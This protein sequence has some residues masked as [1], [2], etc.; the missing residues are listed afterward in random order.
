M[1][2]YFLK[3]LHD[4]FPENGKSLMLMFCLKRKLWKIKLC[5]SFLVTFG[6]YWPGIESQNRKSK[7]SSHITTELIFGY[8][9][10]I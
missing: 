10:T 5:L 6:D 1:K 3:D 4:P 7:I 8:Y 2:P 9:N